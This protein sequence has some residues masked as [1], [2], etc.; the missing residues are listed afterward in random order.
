MAGRPFWLERA[1]GRGLPA[2]PRH[3]SPQALGG[4]CAL[5][6][7]PGLYKP[8]TAPVSSSCG[9][10]LSSGLSDR[11]RVAYGASRST[12]FTAACTWPAAAKHASAPVGMELSVLTA[13]HFDSL[14][15]KCGSAVVALCTL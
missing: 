10:L 8:K 3:M 14:L 2:S 6:D 12:S 5:R 15:F 4:G 13:P 11:H 7:Y 9:K 1:V